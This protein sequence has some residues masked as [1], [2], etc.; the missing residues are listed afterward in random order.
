MGIE[1]LM[2]ERFSELVGR[3]RTNWREFGELGLAGL[4]VKKRG[5][6]VRGGELEGVVDS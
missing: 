4:E 2:I 6:G 3:W 5:L 1:N